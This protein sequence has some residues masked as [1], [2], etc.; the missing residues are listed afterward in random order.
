MPRPGIPEGHPVEDESYGNEE[1]VIEARIVGSPT[2]FSTNRNAA[3]TSVTQ[4]MA[5]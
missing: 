1:F 3:A 2:A 4:R 5:G